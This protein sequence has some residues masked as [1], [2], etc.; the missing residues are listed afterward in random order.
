MPK[1][2]SLNVGMGIDVRPIPPETWWWLGVGT[3]LYLIVWWRVLWGRPQWALGASAFGMI[4]AMPGFMPV[5]FFIVGFDDDPD[6]RWLL[7]AVVASVIVAALGTI[8]LMVGNRRYWKWK[9]AQNELA[10]QARADEAEKL[11]R[12]FGA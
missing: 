1:D 6:T 4:V 7:K 2:M 3:A 9:N 12:K 10:R 8:P 11:L 5:G